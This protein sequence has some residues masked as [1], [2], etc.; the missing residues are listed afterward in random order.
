M[1]AVAKRFQRPGSLDLD[2]LGR[3]QYAELLFSPFLDRPHT[4]KEHGTLV[5][6]IEKP[7]GALKFEIEKDYVK[8]IKS[9]AFGI[10]RS[11]N[12]CEL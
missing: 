12:K 10:Q 11:V 1:P 2:G 7:R 8:G 5:S 6:A 4:E 3:P 9:V